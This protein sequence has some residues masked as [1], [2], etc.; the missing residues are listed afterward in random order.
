MKTHQ[1]IQAEIAASSQLAKFDRYPTVMECWNENEKLW[2]DDNGYSYA[3]WVAN[4]QYE[5]HLMYFDGQLAIA[6]RNGMTIFSHLTERLTRVIN[7]T[8]P[9]PLKTNCPSISLAALAAL[10][11]KY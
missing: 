6:E 4:H 7:E 11:P 5:Y 1:Q 8:E 3:H 9:M 10:Q 2:R